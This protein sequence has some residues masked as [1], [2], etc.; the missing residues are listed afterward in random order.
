[1]FATDIMGCGHKQLNFIFSIVTAYPRLL[2]SPDL[3]WGATPQLINRYSAP[4][5]YF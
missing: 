4:N 5:N 1:M 2:G 3:P